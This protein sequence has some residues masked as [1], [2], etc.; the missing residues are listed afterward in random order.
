MGIDLG[1]QSANGILLDKK[2]TVLLK[3]SIPHTMETPHIGHFEQDAD[4]VWW[5]EFCTISKYL[6]KETGVNP[7]DIVAVGHSATSPC[8]TF[9]DEKNKVLRKG[10]LY[11][12]DTRA[13]KETDYLNEKIGTENLIDTGGCVLS[14]Q[15]VIPKVLWVKNN[16]PEI[17]IKTKKILTANGYIAFKLTGLYTQNFYDAVGFT[18]VFDIF[19]KQWFTDFTGDFIK[20]DI[21]PDLFSA[22]EFIGTLTEEA[23]SATGLS[24]NT[25]VLPGIADAA[26]EGLSA[27][28]LDTGD[29]MLML[30][31]SSFF[32][33]LTEKL[34]KTN[35]FWPSNY[36]FKNEYVITGGTSNCGSAI[37]WF[38]N[39]FLSGEKTDDIY[40]KIR[41]EATQSTITKV[42]PFCVPYLAGERTPLHDPN[43]KGI[44]FGIDF[45]HTRGDLYRALLEGIAFSIK[46]NIEEIRKHAPIK[47]ICAIGGGIKNPLLLKLIADICQITICIPSITHGACYG[48]AIHAIKVHDNSARLKDFVKVK[49]EILPSKEQSELYEERYKTFKKIYE[50]TRCLL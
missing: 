7:E 14:S 40:D 41:A 18:G 36:L 43:A 38:M 10:I 50:L 12:I 24:K 22:S 48:D 19:K 25:L 17:F 47:R 26:A 8:V 28:V 39:T 5:S 37:V 31:T 44:F 32:I 4:T 21:L 29:M 6:I 9:L 3:H 23:S 45:T 49:N 20:R 34:H 46:N 27:G 2:G 13:H 42:S 33:L 11:G 15:S 30:G 35:K 16:E 1:S